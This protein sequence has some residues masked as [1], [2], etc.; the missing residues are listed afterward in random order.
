[1]LFRSGLDA[2]AEEA[3]DV[4]I[5]LASVEAHLGEHYAAA[6]ALKLARARKRMADHGNDGR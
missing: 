3:A 1:M 6:V 5:M 2:V 4:A